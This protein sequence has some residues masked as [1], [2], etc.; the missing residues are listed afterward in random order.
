MQ[1]YLVKLAK[2]SV[3]FTV[4]VI[5]ISFPKTSTVITLCDQIYV[6]R[7]KHLHPRVRCDTGSRINFRRTIPKAFLLTSL[8]EREY[9]FHFSE[10][11]PTLLLFLWSGFI[12]PPP[13][14]VKT[15]DRQMFSRS[16]CSRKKTSR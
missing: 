6:Q 9:N 11:Q 13:T 12:Y 8:Q 16:L 10:I 15:F 4:Y 7:R 3:V 14:R 1:G 5:M 2:A